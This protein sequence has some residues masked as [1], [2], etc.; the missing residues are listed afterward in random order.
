M[1]I[2]FKPRK[3]DKIK[4]YILNKNGTVGDVQ[5]TGVVLRIDGDL[6]YFLQDGKDKPDSFIWRF[7][8]HVKGGYT[9]NRLFSV[10]ETN[11][12]PDGVQEELSPQFEMLTGTHL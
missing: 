8:D 10:T 4:A 1:A 9:Y 2:L 11:F 6:C 7:V 12:L 3:G 5:Y